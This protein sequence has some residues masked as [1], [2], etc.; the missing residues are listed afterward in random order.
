MGDNTPMTASVLSLLLAAAPCLSPETVTL[1]LKAGMQVDAATKW[2]SATFCEPWVLEAGLD[3]KTTLPV[4]ITGKVSRGHAKKL[5]EAALNAADLA[6]RVGAEGLVV[7]RRAAASD[8]CERAAAGIRV[9]GEFE[10]RVTREAWNLDWTSCAATGARVVPSMKEGRPHG[11]KLFAI[12]PDSLFAA[13]GFFNGDLLGDVN[14]LPL[15]SP[16]EVL[17]AVEALRTVEKL[18]FHLTRRDQDVHLKLTVE[19][20]K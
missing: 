8:L 16:D 9:T 14:G 6:V 13:A 10:R 4:S 17:K 11:L 3:A 2:A 15:T 5:F 18:D 12:R 1:A 20:A 19:P 7:S